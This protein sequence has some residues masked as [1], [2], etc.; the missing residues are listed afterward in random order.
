MRSAML[1]AGYSEEYA[2]N[3]KKILSTKGWQEL[4]DEYLPEEK[5]LNRLGEILESDNELSALR[6]IDISIKI[7]G[8]YSPQRF[9]IS[10]SM[11]HLS[12]EQLLAIAFPVEDA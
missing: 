10:S 6:A 7:R 9:D 5:V 3:P 12:D 11:Q 2:N 4:V 1:K 8:D